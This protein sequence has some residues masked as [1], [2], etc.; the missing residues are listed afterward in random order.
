[1]LNRASANLPEGIVLM[2]RD[3]YRSSDIQ[4]KVYSGFLKK[5]KK[6]NPYWSQPRLKEE[7]NKFVADPQGS[8]PGGHTTGAAV[9]VTLAYAKDNRRMAMKTS[10]LSYQEQTHIGSKVP[11]HIRKNRKILYDAMKKAGFVNY[12][13]E[14]WH[15]SF[16]DVFATARQGGKIAIYDAVKQS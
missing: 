1:M 16:G 2:V 5:F 4:R 15:Y 9:D 11:N 10:K 3:A 6:E 7:T 12:P 13:N 14:W 8:I